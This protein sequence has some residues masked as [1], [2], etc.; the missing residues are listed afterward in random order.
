M[1]C[2]GDTHCRDLTHLLAEKTQVTRIAIPKVIDKWLAHQEMTFK[3]AQTRSSHKQPLAI[4]NVCAAF[5]TCSQV[6]PLCWRSSQHGL[7]DPPPQTKRPQNPSQSRTAQH[8]SHL[9][10]FYRPFLRAAWRGPTRWIGNRLARQIISVRRDK[11]KWKSHP[12]IDR[13]ALEL[14]RTKSPLPNRCDRSFAK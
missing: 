13:C 12:A 10:R 2:M 3:L 9:A 14:S 1:G 5:G 4:G 11:N 6:H 7:G 8:P